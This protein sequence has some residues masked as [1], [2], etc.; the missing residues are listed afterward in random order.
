V[1]FQPVIRIENGLG[2]CP[3]RED[4]RLLAELSG[5]APPGRALDLGTGSGYVAIWLARRGW[6]VDAVDV[7]PRALALARRNAELNGVS[8]RIYASDMFGAVTGPYDVI[9]C[10][11]PQRS[12]E[13]EGSRLITATLRRMPPLANLLLRLTQPIL[14]RKRLGFLAEL[15]RGARFHLAPAGRLL[16]VISPLEAAELPKSVPGL[17]TAGSVSVDGIPGLC[18]ATFMFEKSPVGAG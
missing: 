1:N 14:E 17:R 7:S 10:N 15:T 11:P 16:L 13:T 9:A 4:T 8:P 18:V 2:V 12:S 6:D 5:A 3:V